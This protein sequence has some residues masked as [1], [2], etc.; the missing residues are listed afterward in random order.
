MQERRKN[1]R[2]PLDAML[3]CTVSVAGQRRM[4]AAITEVGSEGLRLSF[5]SGEDTAMLQTGVEVEFVES[6]E[7]VAFLDGLK[8][9]V[10]WVRAGVC[11]VAFPPG[12]GPPRGALGALSRRG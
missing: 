3:F 12:G 11:G 9:E 2:V 6:P 5:P 1:S 4:E 10:I 7:E 8:A